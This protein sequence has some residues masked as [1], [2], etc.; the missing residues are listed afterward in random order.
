M[1]HSGELHRNALSVESA[2][3]T[4]TN[5]WSITGCTP[6]KTLTSA[7]SAGKPTG[8]ALIW[9]ITDGNGAQ[10]Q[11]IFALSVGV[12]FNQCRRD[13]NTSVVSQ[14]LTV[15]NAEKALRRSTC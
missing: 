9:P 1:L 14:S 5:S 10:K 11:L 2:L 13:S 8:G 12:V 4:V 6:E 3:Y 7:R 15:L